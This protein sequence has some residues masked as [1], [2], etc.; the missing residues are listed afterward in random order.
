MHYA[1]MSLTIWQKGYVLANGALKLKVEGCWCRAFERFDKRQS[2][3]PELASA[4][5]VSVAVAKSPPRMTRD[6]LG[7]PTVTLWK[8]TFCQTTIIPSAKG[9]LVLE[10]KSMANDGTRLVRS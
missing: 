4:I 3:K 7:V 2:G 10:D 9:C 8:R 6:W 1:Q 5:V